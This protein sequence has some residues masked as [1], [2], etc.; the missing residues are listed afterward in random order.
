MFA[1]VCVRMC[2]NP[3][4]GFGRGKKITTHNIVDQHHI[5]IF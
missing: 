5:E 1:Q 3:V 2:F 4:D